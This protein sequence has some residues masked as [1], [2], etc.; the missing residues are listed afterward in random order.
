MAHETE[1]VPTPRTS[2]DGVTDQLQMPV[3]KAHFIGRDGSELSNVT[4]SPQPN[5]ELFKGT[6]A[7]EPPIDPNELAA[8]FEMSGALRTNIDT[9]ATNIDG[10]GHDFEPV[11]DLEDDDIHEVIRQ[12]LLE[13]KIRE[14]LAEDAGDAEETA[15]RLMRKLLNIRKVVTSLKEQTPDGNTPADSEGETP[16]DDAAL[17]GLN[18]DVTDVEVEEKLEELRRVMVWEE[19]VLK[20]FFDFCCVDMSFTKLRTITRQDQ[21]TLGNGYWEVLRND[22]MEP[23]QFTYIPGYTVRLM[24]ADKKPTQVAML[25]P[26]TL[27]RVDE[28]PVNRRFRRYVQV[29]QD[30]GIKVF[31]KEFGDP[32][33][34]SSKTGKEYKDLKEL[35]RK[36][37]DVAP[38]TELLHF[39]VHSP[40]TPYGIPRWISELLAVLGNRHA[41]EIN[42]AYFEN[43]SIP[44]MAILVSG[45]RLA[46]NEVERLKDFIKNEIRGK[47]NFHK[48]LV[49]QAEPFQGNL[50]GQNSGTVKIEIKPLQQFQNDDGLFMKYQEAN[51]DRIGGVFR[52]PRLLRGDVRDFNRATADASLAFAERQVFSP[53][54]KDFDWAM[55]RQIMPSLGVRF[56]RFVSKG[57]ET[58]DLAELGK[59]LNEAASSGYLSLKEMREIAGRV[60]GR[61]FAVTDEENEDMMVPLELLRL[62]LTE[63]EDEDDGEDLPEDAEDDTIEQARK[64]KL[65]K[66]KARAAL[67][68]LALE[69]HFQ[70]E[71]RDRAKISFAETHA[72]VNG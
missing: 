39:K 12:A 71:A 56:W 11:V 23:V 38:A 70:Q 61:K 44:P 51:S 1:L 59:I 54:R 47:R 30:E 3:V 35:E 68:L 66:R 29:L 53:L 69:A 24:P 19:Q 13:E 63:A 27:L 25:V 67:K 52:N 10:F 48:I 2:D 28:E 34:Y 4:P 65:R 46:T 37:P 8:L 64:R 42:L 62:G 14:Q 55:N 7:I 18:V 22:A 58:T 33:C 50:S 26:R 21:E 5:T 15:K 9:Y 72:L 45:G 41:E 43:K 20:T 36:E 32:R 49:L 57:P 40:R 60:F 31:F 16:E 6:G 17:Q